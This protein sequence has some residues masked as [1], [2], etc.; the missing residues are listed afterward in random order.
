MRSEAQVRRTR[1]LRFERNRLIAARGR[2]AGFRRA[3]RHAGYLP[4]SVELA[5]AR[6]R[7]WIATGI[8]EREED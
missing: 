1:L 5:V 7:E 2:E 8:A 6:D 3:L 4:E